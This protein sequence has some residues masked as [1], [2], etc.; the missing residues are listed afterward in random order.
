MH[1]TLIQKMAEA[2]VADRLNNAAELRHPRPA[3]TSIRAGATPRQPEIQPSRHPHPL[4]A[5]PRRGPASASPDCNGASGRRS[6]D[7]AT[8]ADPRHGGRGRSVLTSQ[9]RR[10]KT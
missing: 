3:E 5:R 4:G 9:A 10:W 1:P 8:A 6:Q 7:L 2:L